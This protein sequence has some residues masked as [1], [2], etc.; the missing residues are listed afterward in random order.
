MILPER[1]RKI[2][3]I[4]PVFS[5]ET[6]ITELC[7]KCNKG[8][9]FF[10]LFCRVFVTE[11]SASGWIDERRILVYNSRTHIQGVSHEER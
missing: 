8:E 7:Q 2:I 3:H 4:I 5:G 10:L 6:I 9:I 1:R 11:L